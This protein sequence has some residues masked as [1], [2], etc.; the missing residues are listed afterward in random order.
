MAFKHVV[1]TER[2]KGC[3]LCKDV[4]PK[5]VLE[6]SDTV[7]AKVAVITV[8][9]KEAKAFDGNVMPMKIPFLLGIRVI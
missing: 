4:C 3:G 1:E 7:S 5:K 6:I 8:K 9:V 2:C